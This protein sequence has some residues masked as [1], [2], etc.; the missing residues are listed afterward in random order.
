MEDEECKKVYGPS[1]LGTDL[2]EFRRSSRLVNAR[3]DFF[4]G[5]VKKIGLKPE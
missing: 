4:K 1:R 2:P 5:V 3:D